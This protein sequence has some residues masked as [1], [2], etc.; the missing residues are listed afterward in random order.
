MKRI[1]SKNNKRSLFLFLPAAMLLMASINTLGADLTKR[2]DDWSSLKT[3][4]D[5]YFASC[6]ACH[7]TRGQGADPT[8][9]GFDPSPPDF[10]DCKFTSREMSN[11]W[12]GIATGGGPMKGFSAMMPAF[13]KALSRDQIEKVVAFIKDFCPEKKWPPGEFNLPKALNTGKAFPEDEAAWSVSGG[14]ENPV[15]VKGKFVIAKR[16]AARHQIEA[17]IPLEVHRIEH[18]AADLY[19]DRRWEISSGDIAAAWKSVLWFSRS[20]GNIVSVTCDVFFPTGNRENGIASEIFIVEPAVAIGQIIPRLGFIQLQGGAELSTDTATK[21]HVVFW[22][23]AF[24]RT[25]RKGG[26]GRAFSPMVEVLGEK[27]VSGN[28]SVNW[29]VVPEFQIALS[30]R[31]HIRLGAGLA[32]P[33]NELDMRPLNIMAYLVWDWYDGGFTEGWK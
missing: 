13:G 1:P 20:A 3:G 18:D 6:V 27:E 17:V 12:V 7:G 10:T 26:F 32:I 14:L 21:S 5:I 24:G 22:R 19:T 23:G 28:T 29:S 9:L 25:F 33:V 30:K 8:M 4:K 31:Q 15:S 16:I 2:R 11:D